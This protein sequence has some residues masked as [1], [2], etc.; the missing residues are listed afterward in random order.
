MRKSAPICPRIR[1]ILDLPLQARINPN[2]FATTRR[3]RW[4][5]NVH[6]DRTGFWDQS[7]SYVTLRGELM[8]AILIETGGG[9]YI[10]DCAAFALVGYLRSLKE[11]LKAMAISHPHVSGFVAC[12]GI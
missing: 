6:P 10:W 11:P 5:N 7:D 12:S 3:P 8:E 4:T 1:P 2:S 9:S